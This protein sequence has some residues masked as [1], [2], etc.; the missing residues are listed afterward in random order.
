MRRQYGKNC[1][2]RLNG[3][4]KWKILNGI[5]FL[6]LAVAITAGYY[7]FF[8]PA[9]FAFMPLLK[10]IEWKFFLLLYIA[11]LLLAFTFSFILARKF[12]SQR[13]FFKTLLALHVAAIMS[14]NILTL[15]T[16]N[17]K[18]N[19][20]K[21]LFRELKKQAAND[22]KADS[23]YYISYGFPIPDSNDLKR[24]SIR[25]S[26][27]IHHRSTC[28]I[29]PTDEMRDLYYEKL[30]REHLNKRNGKNWKVKMEKE[31]AQYP[32]Y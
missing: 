9:P 2:Y 13:T 1:R 30:T 28:I 4:R 25:A 18:R 12:P 11:L 21:E 15:L 3:M 22:I 17:K 16:L 8:Y 14:I 27:G 23:I 6:L 31:L 19:E 7:R 32:A 26:Y 29:D 20:L 24:D 10:E 5:A